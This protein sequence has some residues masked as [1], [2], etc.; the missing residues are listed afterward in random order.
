MV[1][2]KHLEILSKK[3]SSHQYDYLLK[4]LNEMKNNKQLRH[5]YKYRESTYN[6]H[7][8]WHNGTRISKKVIEFDNNGKLKQYNSDC[9]WDKDTFS[10]SVKD[11][12]LHYNG[13]IYA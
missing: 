12:K 2:K 4:T 13:N 1:C 9:F 3:L 5:E 7:G 10:I 6:G 11:D 8:S